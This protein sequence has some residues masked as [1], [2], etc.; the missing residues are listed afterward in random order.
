MTCLAQD[1][2]VYIYYPGLNINRALLYTQKG[3]NFD[4]ILCGH[5]IYG[6]LSLHVLLCSD[7]V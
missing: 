6:H 7:P 1:N 3:P 4:D 5:L 2:P